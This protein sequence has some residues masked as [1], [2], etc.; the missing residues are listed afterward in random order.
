MDLDSG[1]KTVHLIILLGGALVV[2]LISAVVTFKLME[3]KVNSLTISI[4]E[5]RSELMERHIA[6]ESRISNDLKEHKFEVSDNNRAIWQ[7]L[8]KLNDRFDKVF[9]LL[10]EIKSSSNKGE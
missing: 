6:F 3:F 2:P 5:S 7:K 1:I 9:Q 4:R 10:G 8:D